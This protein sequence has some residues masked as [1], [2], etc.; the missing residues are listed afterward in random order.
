MEL[1]PRLQKSEWIAYHFANGISLTAYSPLGNM[2][3]TDHPKTKEAPPPL[4][5]ADFMVVI[6]KRRNYTPAQGGP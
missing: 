2:N 5:K 6:A 3:P 4:L 1:H